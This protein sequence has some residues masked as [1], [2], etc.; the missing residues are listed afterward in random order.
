MCC[1]DVHID[2]ATSHTVVEFCLGYID[3]MCDIKTDA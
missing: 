3:N 2:A 1:I